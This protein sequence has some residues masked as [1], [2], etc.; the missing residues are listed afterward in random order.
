MKMMRKFILLQAEAFRGIVPCVTHLCGWIMNELK[1]TNRRDGA[2]QR[3]SRFLLSTLATLWFKL[4]N[5]IRNAQECDAT[6]AS[7]IFKSRVQK[8]HQ[9]LLN[10]NACNKTGF[11]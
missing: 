1:N 11:K 2:A 3:H 9:I 8:N 5:I 10:A 4:L 6:K 7:F